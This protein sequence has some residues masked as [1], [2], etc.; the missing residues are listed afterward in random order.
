MIR[1]GSTLSRALAALTI[2]SPL[3]LPLAGA[4]VWAAS[5]WRAGGE[6]LNEERS[7]AHVVEAKILQ[8]KQYE[9]VRAIWRGYA[10]SDAAGFVL[11]ETDDEANLVV[12]SHLSKIFERFDGAWIGSE[13]LPAPEVDSLKVLRQEV[14]GEVPEQGVAGFLEALEIETPYIFIDAFD[15][16][17]LPSSEAAT[18]IDASGVSRKETRLE[19]RL[20]VSAYW[21]SQE[22]EE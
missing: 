11:A 1:R 10:G 16:R 5:A 12:S 3:I 9:P 17:Q 19:L 8:M 18:Y 20:R 21:L 6:R 2:S 15:I 4:A 22:G 14:R 7:G 13:E